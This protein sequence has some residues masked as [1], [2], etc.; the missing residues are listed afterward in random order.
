MS[1]KKVFTPEETVTKFLEHVEALCR[2]MGV[3]YD[4]NGIAG[5]HIA[6]IRTDGSKVY[7]A[8]PE[9]FGDASNT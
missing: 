8:G 6:V 7:I 4:S 2:D 5:P 9:R 3:E 1:E